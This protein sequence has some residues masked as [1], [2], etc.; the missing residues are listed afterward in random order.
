MTADLRLLI[1]WTRGWRFQLD[2]APLFW[3]ADYDDGDWS[4]VQLPHDWAVAGDFDV[5]H[6]SGTGYL[7]GGI[8]AYRGR[9]RLDKLASRLDAGARVILLCE[10]IYKRATLWLNGSQIG[11]NANGYSRFSYDVTRY[12]H[13]DE[14]DNVLAIRVDHPDVADS[15]WYTGSG[16][17]RGLGLVVVPATHLALDGSYMNTLAL[18]EDGGA[19]LVLHSE[20]DHP[21]AEVD[22]A[23]AIRHRLR[24]A[25]GREVLLSERA[26]PAAERCQPPLR[27]AIWRSTLRYEATLD[28][29]ALWSP[30]DPVRYQLEIEL[31]RDGAVID[32]ERQWVGVRHADWSPERGFLLNGEPLKLRGVCVHHDAGCLGAAVPRAVWARRIAILRAAGCNAIRMSHNPHDP[33]LMELCDEMGMLAIAEAFDEWEGTKNKWARGHN[34]YPPELRGYAEDYGLWHDFDLTALVRRDRRHPSV[35][36]WSIGNEI[37]YPNDPYVH[38]AMLEVMGNN[39]ANKPVEER[40]FSTARPR[41]ELLVPQAEE[42][43]AR[44]RALDP[45]R[46]VTAALAFPEVSTLTG[47]GEVLDVVGYNYKEGHYDRDHKRFPHW[48]LLGSENSKSWQAAMDAETRDFIG[49]Q[50]LWTGIDFLGETAGWPSHGSGAGIMDLAGFPKPLYWLRQRLW[51]DEPM[52]HLAVETAGEPAYDWRFEDRERTSLVPGADGEIALLVVTNV[53]ARGGR[54][55]I[56]TEDEEGEPLAVLDDAAQEQEGVFRLTLARPAAG[57]VAVATLADGGEGPEVRL[58]VAQ[59]AAAL[60]VVRQTVEGLEL[61]ETP[62]EGEPCAALPAIPDA[63]LPRLVNQVPELTA[64]AEALA[65]DVPEH[66]LAMHAPLEQLLVEAVDV[67]GRRVE[68]EEGQLRVAVGDGLVLRGLENGRLDDPTPYRVPYRR[69]SQGRLLLYVERLPGAAAED[70]WLELGLRGLAHRRYMLG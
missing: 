3:R 63:R 12:L 66:T 69:L 28:D 10:G 1:P 43:A 48:P 38:P 37:D 22:G 49:G 51:L 9:L 16:I 55:A 29:A 14:R 7:P 21:A 60:R 57:L 46:P 11:T 17:T 24:D 67:A 45:T 36:L 65:A 5:R 39:D 25:A 56:Y 34:V 40:R 13:T 68:A 26:L 32:R 61:V 42:L 64:E 41:A 31:L 35:I 33:G 58:P 30:D 50:F 4:P 19:R 59:P 70:C 8:G 23:L 52:L 27:P 18:S 62:L 6:S 54:V 47:L 15:R 44:V 2:P 53:V 20:V